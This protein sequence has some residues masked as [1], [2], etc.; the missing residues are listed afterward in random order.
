MVDMVD[1]GQSSVSWEGNGTEW[2]NPKGDPRNGID[3]IC[4]DSETGKPIVN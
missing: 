1:T 2:N 4:Q 3:F